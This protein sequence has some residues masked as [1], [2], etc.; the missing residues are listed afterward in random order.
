[1]EIKAIMIVEIAGRPAEHIKTALDA[2]VSQIEKIKDV[3][4]ISKKISEPKRLE[5]EQ[6]IYTCFAEVEVETISLSKITELVF[7]FMPSS[8]E[9]IEP[10]DVRLDS[11]E[12]SM[13]LND[14]AGR[15]H[16]Y[17]E[18]A[19]IAQF[20]IREL[21]TQLQQLQQKPEEKPAK[22]KSKKKS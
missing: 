12:A 22:K 21:A 1:M 14:L 19:K 6:E 17:D 20:K 13:F 18:I 10:A 9:I 7:D 11:Q 2:H 15:L 3:K 8:I 4:L 5:A 16:R